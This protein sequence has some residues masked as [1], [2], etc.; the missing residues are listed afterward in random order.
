MLVGCVSF[1][2]SCVTFAK[3]QEL[4]TTRPVTIKG[5]QYLFGG[6]LAG[7]RRRSR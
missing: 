6:S 4:M 1:S 2:G 5:G 3:L 7:R